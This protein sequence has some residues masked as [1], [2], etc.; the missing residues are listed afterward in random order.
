MALPLFVVLIS[1]CSADK[2][3]YELNGGTSPLPHPT[4]QTGDT[5]RLEM[6]EL[7]RESHELFVVHRTAPPRS[8]ADSVVNYAYAYDTRHYHSRWVA[9]RFDADTRPKSVQRKPYNIR[10]QYPRDPKLPLR[11]ALPDDASFNGYDHGHLC[12]SADRLYSRQANDQTFY[13]SNMS[14]QDNAFNAQYWSGLEQI[15]QRLGRDAS[16]ADTLYVV[17]GG[18]ILPQSN[19]LKH[20]SSGRVP[21]P[22]FY[23][24][25]L[26]KV[27]N[28]AYSAI[29]FWLEHKDYGVSGTA[30]RMRDHVVSIAQLQRLTGIN[31][32][33]NLPDAVETAV[34]QNAVPSAWTL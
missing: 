10:P 7:T 33:H 31:F 16:F 8:G 9:F 1:A 29:G 20:V 19:V 25:A 14:P 23:F 11:Y 24:M 27:K 12:A 28:G 18:T 6:P 3:D 13:L 32:F 4:P 5:A 30:A 22:K 15:V 17:K 34:E 26:L 21:V 2:N